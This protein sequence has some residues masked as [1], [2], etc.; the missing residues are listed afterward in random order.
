MKCL[1]SN[2][3]DTCCD[4]E[5]STSHLPPSR[6]SIYQTLT[7]ALTSCNFGVKFRVWRTTLL[8]CPRVA[9]AT[10]VGDILETPLATARRQW[11]PISGYRGWVFR[12]SPGGGAGGTRDTR[13]SWLAGAEK[14]SKRWL[15][16]A[17]GK[18]GSNE[19]PEVRQDQLKQI[20]QYRVSQWKLYLCCQEGVET[21]CITKD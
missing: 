9:D 18:L 7:E 17:E 16:P 19:E 14:P 13:E 12:S 15:Q 2:F 4:L 21:F 3:K 1:S 6:F 8:L 10:T 11:N 5:P 20:K